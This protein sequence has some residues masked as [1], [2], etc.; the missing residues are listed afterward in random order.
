MPRADRI[1]WIKHDRFRHGA[2]EAEVFQAHLR[3]AVFADGNANVRANELHVEVRESGQTDEI[4]S[5]SE[6]AGESRCERDFAGGC[7]AHRCSDHVLFGNVHLEEA[8][9]RDFLEKLGVGGVLDVAV[10]TNNV[11][12]GFANFRKRQTRSFACRNLLTKFVLRSR[13]VLVGP[14]VFHLA[15]RLAWHR[16]WSICLYKLF[17]QFCNCFVCFLLLQRFAM[18]AVLIFDE[19]DAFTFQRLRQDYSWIS[20]CL[21]GVVESVEQ[22]PNIVAINDQSVPSECQPS[23][24]VNVHVMLKH[25]WLALAETIHVY[26]C[27]KVIYFVMDCNLSSFPNRTFGILAIA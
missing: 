21:L 6:K 16:F 14:V 4:G 12:I 25:R 17:L 18:P 22:L 23:L 24:P 5:A 7:E 19:G 3:R 15:R 27:A 26:D 8:I 13:D 20:F 9:R 11:L 10:S 2:E 1:A